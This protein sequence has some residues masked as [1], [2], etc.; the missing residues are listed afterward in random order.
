VEITGGMAH[1]L[2]YV[3]GPERTL[4]RLPAT[5]SFTEAAMLEA[6]FGGDSRGTRIAGGRRRNSLVIGAGMIGL[7]T[8]QAAR[9]AGCAR[10]LIADVDATR[11]NLA[12]QVGAEEIVHCSGAELVAEYCCEPWPGRRSGIRGRW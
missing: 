11:L 12:R 3:V 1:L 9:A 6:R 2:N 4:Y 8:L 7:L 5:I 10:V